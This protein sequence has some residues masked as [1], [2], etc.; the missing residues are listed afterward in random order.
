[1]P[2]IGTGNESVENDKYIRDVNSLIDRV[3]LANESSHNL[4]LADNLVNLTSDQAKKRIMDITNL[5]CDAN[6]NDMHISGC[7][8]ICR[9]VLSWLKE[10]KTNTVN[11]VIIP[12]DKLAD[13]RTLIVNIVRAYCGVDPID[14]SSYG[15]EFNR[16]MKILQEECVLPISNRYE[17][18]DGPMISM[19]V[20]TRDT[21]G[22]IKRFSSDAE[23]N[24]LLSIM[25]LNS[26]SIVRD[27][28]R[29]D[30]TLLETLS[31]QAVEALERH[32]IH[33][34]VPDDVV[35]IDL[36]FPD[37]HSCEASAGWIRLQNF[38]NEKEVLE[39]FVNTRE[40]LTMKVENIEGIGDSLV[41]VSN[42]PPF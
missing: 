17:T 10:V 39:H 40:K 11:T 34:M 13:A 9:E 28:V 26:D 21:E 8:R 6:G 27:T 19:I 2:N 25:D 32:G 41:I 15:L 30:N 38:S 42:Y 3:N 35:V 1:M 37:G 22:R 16:K 29:L 5:I 24:V 31:H 18:E 7:V 23:R 33:S 12:E 20:G 14:G 36:S 4:S